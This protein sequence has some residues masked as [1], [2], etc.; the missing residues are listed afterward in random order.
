MCSAGGGGRPTIIVSRDSVPGGTDRAVDY[1]FGSGSAVCEEFSLSLSCAVG[2][3]R[4]RE[5]ITG[6]IQAYL[7]TDNRFQKSMVVH[8]IVNQIKARGGRFLKQDKTGK[9][10]ELRD[11][12]TKEKVGHAIRDAA[13][14]W[15]N[16]QK[17][18][19]RND[20]RLSDNDSS[21][22]SDTKMEARQARP[23]MN[24]TF[25]PS[26]DSETSSPF[27]ARPTIQPSLRFPQVPMHWSPLGPPSMGAT[28]TDVASTIPHATI[29]AYSAATGF[30]N[31]HT[32]SPMSRP[33]YPIQGHML[34]Q[35]LF[36]AAN[37][38]GHRPPEDLYGD[39]RLAATSNMAG[40]HLGGSSTMIS[41]TNELNK[42]SRIAAASDSKLP[43]AAA[44]P[45]EK[46]ASTRQI[47]ESPP[48]DNFLDQINQV[49]GPAAHDDDDPDVEEEPDFDTVLQQ[50]PDP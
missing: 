14:A 42:D 45:P 11:Q 38:V 21:T 10:V 26:G 15:E 29:P 44:A 6:T 46:I 30:A 22:H 24:R 5:A 1:L 16:R 37:Q 27:P 13:S 34:G 8:G 17:K 49:L 4:F 9:W 33:M 20:G 41:H 12:Q 35:S 39:G 18:K 28:L 43:F 50:S 19:D 48:T 31:L 32:A 23:T 25:S 40:S 3:Q 7:N 36:V 47:P 2:N